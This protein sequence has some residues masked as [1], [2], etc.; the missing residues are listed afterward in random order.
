MAIWGLCVEN[1]QQV[2]RVGLYGTN[3]HQLPLGLSVPSGA[4]VVAV[5][6]Y[7]GDRLDA[8]EVGRVVRSY[9]TLEALLA[10]P[11]VDL[12]SL[13]SARR[14]EQADQAIQCLRA[15]KHVLAEK[16]CAFTEAKLDQILAAAARSGRQFREMAASTSSLPPP[17]QAIRRLVDDG[18][19]GTIVHVQAHKSYPWHDRRPQE[20]AVDGG[21]VRQVG[22][23]AVRFIHSAT[24]LRIAAIRGQSTGLGRPEHVR[25]AGSGEIHRGP[26]RA[27][28]F[29]LELEN[30]GVGSINLNY[31]NPSNFGAWGNDQVRVFGT[32]GM[33]ETVDGFRR[34]SAYIPGRESTELPFPDDLV[35]PVYIAHYARYL[36][37]GTPMP[38][39]FEE[40]MAM[41][42]AMLALHEAAVTG[43]R[44]TVRYPDRDVNDPRE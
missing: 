23:H 43:A 11:E 22:I 8:E 14:I 13:C 6:D 38:I 39:P 17:I 16:P 9:D 34:S 37:D 42:R 24:G 30:G 33:A 3:G 4:R 31:L 41:T 32:K 36:L 2:I 40:E 18:T 1:E 28:V 20:T 12:V 10:D 5:A 44:V 21:L 15:G 35:S 27:A 25:L 26:A 19:L 29:A 7:P